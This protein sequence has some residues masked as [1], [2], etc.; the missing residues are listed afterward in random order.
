MEKYKEII[1]I[2][3]KQKTIAPPESLTDHLMK[4]L[5]DQYPSIVF[6]A[7]SFVHN[8]YRHALEPDSDSANGLTRRECSFYFFIT[9]LFYLIIGI[10]LMMGLQGVNTSIT[11]MEWIKLQ[12]HLTIGTAIWLLALGLVL[13]LNGRSGIMAARYGTMLYFLFAVV[14]GILMRNYIHF[15]FSSMFIIGFVGTS[16]LMGFMLT[17]AV[18]KVE[19]RSI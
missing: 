17:H 11:A 4:R 13:M 16:V 8:L 15:P 7:A 19:L 2:L 12:P 14:N 10:I 18:K 1:E 9:G 5:P 6:V 3:Q